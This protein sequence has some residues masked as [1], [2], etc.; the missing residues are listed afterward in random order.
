MLTL[1]LVR[2]GESEHNAAGRYQGHADAPLTRAGRAQ[3]LALRERL[4][5]LTTSE[6]VRVVSSDLG[7]ARETAEIV[8][9]DRAITFD[10]RL[11]ELHFGAFEGCS[12]ETCLA[13]HGALY[14]SW[15]IGPSSVRP[16]GG[17]TLAELEA[18]VLDWL[19][20]QPPDGVTI[21]ITHG[22]P[23]FVL[24]ARLLDI[25]FDA[26]RRAGLEHG[27][28]VRL[29]LSDRPDAPVPIPVWLS[30]ETEGCGRT[31]AAERLAPAL[32]IHER[33]LVPKE[34]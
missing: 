1:V 11:R 22:G 24:L 25:P 17:E 21:A 28:G 8:M 10:S 3:A 29:L 18:R 6:P 9:P 5:R 32:G 30:D 31:R 27:D 15:L 20:T 34:P 12:H 23:V 26:A 33:K 14:R 19:D 13:M 4:A 16:P 2:H 7:R